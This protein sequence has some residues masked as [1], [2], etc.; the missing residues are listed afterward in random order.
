MTTEPLWTS[1]AMAEA[2]RAATNG[3]MPQAITGISID[4]RTITPGEAYFAIK[5]ELHDG[6]DFVAAALNA[7]AALAVAA[8]APRDSFGGA[9]PVLGGDGVLCGLGALAPTSRAR[10][11]AR[12]RAGSRVWG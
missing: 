2:M 3:A 10:L 8:A 7:G 12:R 11:G 9:A 5:G 6:H 4:S 1:L